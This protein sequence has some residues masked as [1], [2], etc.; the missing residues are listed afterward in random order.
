MS[1][2]IW[3]FILAI[4]DFLPIWSCMQY[5]CN[6]NCCDY[7]HKMQ[8]FDDYYNCSEFRSQAPKL[9]MNGVANINPISRHACIKLELPSCSSVLLI[10]PFPKQGGLNPTL[11]IFA[12]P[13]PVLEWTQLLPSCFFRRTI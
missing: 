6:V 11:G 13:M 2:Y 1:E 7:V 10:R 9:Q 4:G 8:T 5:I 3:A 12:L